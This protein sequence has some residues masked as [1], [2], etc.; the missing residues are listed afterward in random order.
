[1]LGGWIFY[2]LFVPPKD[3]E[4]Y[5]TWLVLGLAAVPFALICVIAV[6]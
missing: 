3:P 4:A 6:W 1:M 2:H 5:R